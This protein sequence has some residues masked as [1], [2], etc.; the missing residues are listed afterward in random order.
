MNLGEGILSFKR[1]R[2]G[3]LGFFCLWQNGTDLTVFLGKTSEGQVFKKGW[4]V[5]L[6]QYRRWGKI[7]EIERAEV[8]HQEPEA[9]QT[10]VAVTL[11]RL[12]L[13]QTFRFIKWGRPVESQVRDHDGQVLALAG[14]RPPRTFSTF[15]I[16]KNEAEMVNMVLGKRKSQDGQEHINAMQERS[17]KPFH[18]EFSTM[19]FLPLGESG[20]YLGKSGYIQNIR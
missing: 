6:R 5:R 8:F 1:F 19:R 12:N 10:V 14:F 13:L 15:S 18:H 11:A 7:S 3:T 17:R 9:D 20:K 16:W 4:F 2:F